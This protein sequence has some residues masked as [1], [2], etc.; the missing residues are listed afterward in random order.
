MEAG[1]RA[2]LE[3]T[4][5]RSGAESE[6]L[7]GRFDL[8]DAVVGLL[9]GDA[10]AESWRAASP[11]RVLDE[12]HQELASGSFDPL[13]R[14]AIEARLRADLRDPQ[15]AGRDLIRMAALVVEDGEVGA[16]PPPEGLSAKAWERLQVRVAELAV[17]DRVRLL[18]APEGQQDLR[19][20]WIRDDR[21]V[22]SLVDYRGLPVRDL[23]QGE[24]TQGLHRQRIE[25]E[26]VDGRTLSERAADAMLAEM[27]ERIAYQAAHDTLT[28]LLNRLQFQASLQQRL[29]STRT[30]A[31][32]G[33]LLLIDVDHF[34]LINNVHGYEAGDRLLIGLARLLERRCG[35]G[36]LLGHH[37]GDRFALLVPELDVAEGDRRAKAI[38]G[39][40]AGF[41]SGLPGPRRGV[42][43]SIGVVALADA[44][45]GS[46]QALRAAEAAVEAAKAAGGNQPY[47]YRPDDPEITRRQESVRWIGL[48]DDALEHGRLR[49]RCQPIVPVQ[50]APGRVPHYEVL[51]GVEDAQGQSLSVGD[52]ITAAET[53]KRITAIDRWV[54][55]TTFEWVAAHR[56]KMPEFHGFAVN[57]S[58]QTVGDASF[59]EFVRDLFRRTEIRPEWISF[60]VTETAVIGDLTHTAAIVRAI[61]ELGCAVALD[62]FGSGL[63]SYSYLKEL[64]VDWLKIDGVF[65]RNLATDQND[66]AVVRSIN[67]IAHFMGKQTIA[68]YV[69]DAQVLE[70]IRSLGVD[71]AQGFGIAPPCLLDDL[72]KPEGAAAPSAVRNPLGPP[73]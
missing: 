17:G 53:Y 50:P 7:A 33:V 5:L 72:L 41:P 61:K 26:R 64:P 23:T 68:E 19:V 8:L 60:E 52:F 22:Y 32:P 21:Q 46:G 9:G 66:F 34:H 3:L 59:V 70:K 56:D 40:I 45:E 43:V 20:A 63:A 54:T 14:R 51:L 42:T 15:A 2:V 73:T 69:V 18:D 44:P 28:G 27:E 47:C 38:C 10:Y 67:E 13:R 58:G 31:R 16:S 65:V 55:R 25:H 35:E 49:L 30:A 39:W 62:D 12:L 48:V 1:W 57:L 24:L 6:A 36:N 4:F 29:A 71:F 11:E 37:G